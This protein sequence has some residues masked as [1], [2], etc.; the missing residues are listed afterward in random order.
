MIY[1]YSK[2]PIIPVKELSEFSS[3]EDMIKDPT[4]PLYGY[5][6]DFKNMGLRNLLN[7]IFIEDIL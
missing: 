2:I 4:S 1:Y 6:E 5:I 7:K 3:W